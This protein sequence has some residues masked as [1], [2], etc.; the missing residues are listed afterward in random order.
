MILIVAVCGLLFWVFERKS[1]S[2]MFGGKKRQGTRHGIVVVDN[3]AAWP[4]R[5]HAGEHDGA[6]ACDDGDVCQPD[7]DFDFDRRHHI[8][9]DRRPVRYGHQTVDRFA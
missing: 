3:L 6:I 2:T 8:G 7:S 1:N 4:Q 9:V 5:N